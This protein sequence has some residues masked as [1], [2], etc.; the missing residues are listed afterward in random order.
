MAKPIKMATR[1]LVLPSLGTKGLLESHRPILAISYHVWFLLHLL[2]SMPAA[3]VAS[4]RKGPEKHHSLGRKWTAFRI[5]PKM[6]V[7]YIMDAHL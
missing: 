5:S 4:T 6:L 1:R 2:Q 3:A 7:F